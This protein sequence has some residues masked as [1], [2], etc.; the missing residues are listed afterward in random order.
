MTFR[1]VATI[2]SILL[3]LLGA[4]YLFAGG[5]LV[6]RWNIPATD[7]VLLVARRIGAIYLGLSVLFFKAKNAP[8][9]AARAAITAGAV[10]VL[11][12]LVILGVYEFV[13]G[14]VGA[15]IFV[16]AGIELVLAIGFVAVLL[17]ERKELAAVTGR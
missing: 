8:V 4:G 6:G 5:V 17:G 2:T 9:S 14:R 11:S 15:G 3:F 1:T 10:A 7:E 16:S 12:L 13:V